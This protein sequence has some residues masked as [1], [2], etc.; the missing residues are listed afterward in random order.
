MDARQS[1]RAFRLRDG[2]RGNILIHD[3]TGLGI[4]KAEIEFVC[5]GS[6]VD[7]GDHDTRQLA[8][9]MQR[10]SGFAILKHRGEMIAG[11]Q[12]DAVE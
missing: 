3:G 2:L 7:R 4:F 11:F 1:G 6:P 9:P 10:R 8:G 5:L 12:A